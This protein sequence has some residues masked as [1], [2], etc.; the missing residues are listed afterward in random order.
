M[1]DKKLLAF[2][3]ALALPPL[4]FARM[5]GSAQGTKVGFCTSKLISPSASRLTSMWT[6][7]TLAKGGSSAK[8]LKVPIGG[9]VGGGFGVVIVSPK[10]CFL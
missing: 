3:L 5:P 1:L 10:G 7:K 4:I 2:A 6:W 8:S 9:C